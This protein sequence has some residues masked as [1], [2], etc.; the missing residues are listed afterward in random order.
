MFE[1]LHN[2]SAPL[3]SQLLTDHVDIQY[4]CPE[5]GRSSNTFWMGLQQ[6]ICGIPRIW[7]LDCRTM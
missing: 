4:I 1:T 7:D 2:L 6:S 3:N 5:Q